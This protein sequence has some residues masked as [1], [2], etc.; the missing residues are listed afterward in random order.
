[1][2]GTPSQNF[3][4]IFDTSSPVTWVMSEKCNSSACLSV[5]NSQ[6]YHPETSSTN[7]KFPFRI[8]LSY[9]DGSHVQLK[10]ELVCILG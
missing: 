2:L 1:M 3:V 7:F 6:K 9:L 4:G 5:Q 8:D 10:P